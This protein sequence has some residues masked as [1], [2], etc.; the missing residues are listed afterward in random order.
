MAIT[1][2]LENRSKIV[3]YEKD[4]CAFM[5]EAPADYLDDV[6]KG[7]VPITFVKEQ[8]KDAI[9]CLKQFKLK[10]AFQN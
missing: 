5:K 7:D 6:S 8:L 2:K 1:R 9:I 10:P 3:K 4:K